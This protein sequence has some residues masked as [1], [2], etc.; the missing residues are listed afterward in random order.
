MGET[1]FESF[2]HGRPGR[3]IPRG[4]HRLPLE[5]SFRC[6]ATLR[7]PAVA[8]M[9][10]YEEFVRLHEAISAPPRVHGRRLWLCGLGT[11]LI[12][13]ALMFAGVGIFR[14][15]LG[16]QV[17]AFVGEGLDAEAAALAYAVCS[18]TA[19]LQA[20]ALL[21]VL[22]AVSERPVKAFLWIGV[23]AVTLVTLLPFTLRVPVEAALA[24]SALDLAGGSLIVGLLAGVAR[25]C[26]EWP[27]PPPSP[28]RRRG[29]A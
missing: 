14:G 4:A 25:A 21:R 26:V 1:P 28:Y 10:R 6:R 11:A 7:G 13:G 27:E 17:P 15:L 24:T 22:L 29:A 3:G 18:S 20:T 23:T 16:I 8:P 9:A 2:F 19:T 12:A 5:R